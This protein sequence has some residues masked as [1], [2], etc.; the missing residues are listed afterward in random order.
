MT[1]DLVKSPPIYEALL[2]NLIHDQE[3][4]QRESHHS[5]KTVIETVVQ[6]GSSLEQKQI[7][8]VNWPDKCLVIAIKRGKQEIL[9][10][11]DTRIKAG[12][13]LVVLTDKNAEVHTRE[14]LD[15]LVTG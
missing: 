15:V 10:T 1:A 11:G 2:E 3:G 5:L 9:P 13:Y 4:E 12:D 7:K 8:E 14:V 6:Y